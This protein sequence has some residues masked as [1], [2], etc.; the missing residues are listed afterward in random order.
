MGTLVT[1]RRD[2]DDVVLRLNGAA[3]LALLELLE[4]TD[5]DDFAM[6]ESAKEELKEVKFQAETALGM[7]RM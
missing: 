5:L 7:A 6:E 2:G 3:A 1:F 4:L